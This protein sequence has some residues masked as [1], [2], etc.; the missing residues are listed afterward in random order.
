MARKVT[1]DDG[2]NFG[3]FSLL[4]GRLSAATD[5][6]TGLPLVAMERYAR[7][8]MVESDNILHT[9]TAAQFFVSAFH[10]PTKKT[11]DHDGE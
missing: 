1:T 6:I 11:G 7:E 5:L 10:S 8:E 9:V 2:L 4:L 3:E